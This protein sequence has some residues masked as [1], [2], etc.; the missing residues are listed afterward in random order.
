VLDN[1]F[2]RRAARADIVAVARAHQVTARCLWLRTELGDAQV[3]AV[4]RLVQRY[5]ELPGPEALR[6]L[7]KRDPHAFDPRA[8]FRYERELEPPSCEEGLLTVDEV[9]FERETPPGNKPA[10]FIEVDE[11]LRT[12]L[13]GARS[14]RSVADQEVRSERAARLADHAARGY[15]LFGLAWQ[16][17]VEEGALSPSAVEEILAALAATLDVPLELAFCPHGAGPPRCWCRRPLPGLVIALAERHDVD[18]GGSLV[19]GRSSSDRTMAARLGMRFVD[20]DEFFVA[21]T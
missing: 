1:T 11:V 5:G 21:A 13:S 14:P 4:R 10:I 2:A 15:R 20:H 3:N 17:E 6:R 16:P 7:H 19:V 9:A 12:S 18:L 8:Q